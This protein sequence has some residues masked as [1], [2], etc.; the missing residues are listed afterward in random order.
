MIM[1]IMIKHLKAYANELKTG[2]P[3]KSEWA[4]RVSGFKISPGFQ[5]LVLLYY[6][7]FKKSVL[8]CMCFFTTLIFMCI[9]LKY[10]HLI[11]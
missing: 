8:K 2:R 10:K 6:L 11:F 5:S 1:M 3:G 4:Q 9:Q 7:E